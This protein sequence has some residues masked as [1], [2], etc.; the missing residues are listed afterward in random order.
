MRTIGYATALFRLLM[1]IAWLTTSVLAPAFAQVDPGGEGGSLGGS[2]PQ[3]E[4]A[5]RPHAPSSGNPVRRAMPPRP[6]RRAGGGVAS[7]DGAWSVSAG[8]SCA[9][10][11]TSEVTI[12]R[13]RIIGQGGVSGS[14]SPGGGV[15]TMSALN[16]MT[17]IGHGRIT[18]GAASGVYRQSDGCTGPWSAV[19]L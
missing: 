9:S 19:R 1:P 2:L 13:G 6:A 18:G 7:F 11:G 14:V 3:A 12:S 5:E 8:G 10:A 4:P 15:S 17:I 16:G